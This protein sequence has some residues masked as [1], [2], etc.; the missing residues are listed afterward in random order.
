MRMLPPKLAP[1]ASPK[2][3]EWC[4]RYLSVHASKLGPDTIATHTCI[5][6]RHLR[7]PFAGLHL[8]EIDILRVQRFIDA[9]NAAGVKPSTR[10]PV[11]AVG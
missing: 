2:W 11:S 4:D 1:G 7:K 3:G 5:V 8:H 6:N 9:S 10:E